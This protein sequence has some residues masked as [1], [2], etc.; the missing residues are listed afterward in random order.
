[1]RRPLGTSAREATD[2]WDARAAPDAATKTGEEQAGPEPS[3][4]SWALERF[5]EEVK[6]T[7]EEETYTASKNVQQGLH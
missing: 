6:A 5:L 3:G 2:A 4:I 7:K 1:M